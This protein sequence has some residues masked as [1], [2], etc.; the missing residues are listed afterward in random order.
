[1]KVKLFGLAATIALATSVQGSFAQEVDFNGERIEWTVPFKEGGGTDT[2]ARFFVSDVSEMLPGQPTVVIKN[3]PGGGSINGAN[4]FDARAKSDGTSIFGSTASTLFY[5]LLGDKRAR[6]E[7]KS[8][9]AVF[10]TPTGGVLYT[11]PS[12]GISSPEDLATTEVEFIFPSLGPTSLDLVPLLAMDMLGVN[13]RP[14][15]GMD[16]S[17]GRLAFERGEV[18]IDY[19]TSA[20]F[21]QK[22]MPLVNSGAAQPL[23]SWGVLDGEGNIVR[24]PSFPD[25][26][27]FNE[28]YE[29]IHGEAPS[30]QAYDV[31]KTFFIA[32]F[33]AQKIMFLPSTA[34]DST[35][36]AY[37]E[38]MEKV[39]NAPNFKERASKAIGDYDQIVG[40]NVEAA[41]KMIFSLSEED[42]KW[43]QNWLTQKYNVKF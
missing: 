36:T 40:N 16:R 7:P 29:R 34:T 31:W 32:G 26:P 1:M 25:L 17:A 38:T 12:L 21:I 5:Y 22:V 30:G 8:W 2:W 4:Q 14:V 9:R 28:V 15:F 20:P 10:A 42:K 11:N 3:V 43:I 18:N 27:T 37:R 6:Y 23:L 39:V 41:T 13:V 35:L 33:A 19:Q 24:D